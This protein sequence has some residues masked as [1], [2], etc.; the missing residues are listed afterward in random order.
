MSNEYPTGPPPRTGLGAHQAKRADEVR[1]LK[2]DEALSAIWARDRR[3]ISIESLILAVTAVFVVACIGTA[4][5]YSL[6]TIEP[7]LTGHVAIK[8]VVEQIIVA[9]SNGDPNAKNKNSSA[10]GAGQFLDETWLEMIRTHRPDLVQMRSNKEI[11]ELRRNPELVR[12]IATRL[13]EKNAAMLRARDLPVTPGT[14]YL[15]YF[16]GPAGGVAIL[17]D[18][19]NADAASLLANA[20]STGRT[21]PEKLISANPFLNG[22]TA[23]ELKH[24]A[25]R[26]MRSYV[27]KPSRQNEK[28]TFSYVSRPP[29]YAWR[30]WAEMLSR[31]DRLFTWSVFTRALNFLRR[32]F[33]GH[34]DDSRATAL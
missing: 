21:T 1:P 22:M 33:A 9:E 3:W 4:R 14:L 27:Q 23:G 16:A 20:D 31:V 15:T 25:D 10:T 18:S 8:A 2:P 6:G 13:L 34:I 17:S 26:K 32:I 7:R 11:L 24:W 29:E 12:E 19:E 5:L 30:T 28:P